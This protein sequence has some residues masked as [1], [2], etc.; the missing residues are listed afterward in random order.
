MSLL[1]TLVCL[2][3]SLCVFLCHF[4]TQALAV[5]VIDVSDALAKF[6]NNMFAHVLRTQF[7]LEKVCFCLYLFLLDCK[8]PARYFLS[9]RVLLLFSNLDHFTL[10][11]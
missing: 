2:L 8:T 9:A 4:V 10:S 11:I 5:L 1:S 6:G 7:W 3:Q